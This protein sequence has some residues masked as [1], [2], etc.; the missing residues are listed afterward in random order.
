MGAALTKITSEEENN[1]VTE[2]AKQNGL[3]QEEDF[4]IGLSRDSNG[5]GNFGSWKWSDGSEFQNTDYQKWNDDEPQDFEG[6]AKMRGSTEWYGFV[7]VAL[8]RGCA[9]NT[10]TSN[11]P[12]INNNKTI[13]NA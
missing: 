13:S 7:C 4:W 10:A 6:C 3:R 12:Q 5:D 2:L 1:F 11:N 8:I 9:K